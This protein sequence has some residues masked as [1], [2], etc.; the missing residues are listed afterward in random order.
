MTVA[1][2]LLLSSFLV[3]IVSA[4]GFIVTLANALGDWLGD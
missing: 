3:V 1:E 2:S 4:M